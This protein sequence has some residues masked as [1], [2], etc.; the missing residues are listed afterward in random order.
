[1]TT[2]DRTLLASV[3][4]GDEQ[5]L[6]QLYAAYRPRLWRYVWHQLDG[7][8]ELVD[9]VLQDVFL[10]IWRT[11][12]AYRGEAAIAT[13]IFRITHHQTVSALRSRARRNG[14]FAAKPRDNDAPHESTGRQ[15]LPPGASHEDEVV[16]R[17]TLD[18]ALSRISAKHRIV[19]ELIF[20]YGFSCEEAARV[21]DVPIGTVKSRLSYARK[22]LNEQLTD[23][24]TLAEA[25]H[26]A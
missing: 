22:A 13:W 25:Q 21:L 15:P 19:L 5:A 18:D 12:H 4:A 26:D 11:A 14:L 23:G 24:N 17:I 2:D 20:F 6:E 3:V 7:D 9:D 8:A 1:M 10:A 16:G